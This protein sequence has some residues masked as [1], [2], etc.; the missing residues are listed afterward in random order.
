MVLPFGQLNVYTPNGN[1]SRSGRW[2]GPRA[3]PWR[4]HDGMEFLF[5]LRNYTNVD[6]YT[7]SIEG[8]YFPAGQLNDPYLGEYTMILENASALEGEQ[9]HE[10]M[11][12]RTEI[13]Q[14]LI[15]FILQAGKYRVCKLLLSGSG[16]QI[17]L[18]RSVYS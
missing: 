7:F 2:Y 4:D 3:A 17:S 10:I 12:E 6:D 18:E 13:V 14:S 9:R 15:T 11:M 16:I 1:L 8:S 5:D